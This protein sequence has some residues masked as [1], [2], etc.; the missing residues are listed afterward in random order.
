[1]VKW[2]VLS[3]SFLLLDK[4][5][6][7]LKTCGKPRALPALKLRQAGKVRPFLVVFPPEADP[8]PEGKAGP[9][10]EFPTSFFYVLHPTNYPLNFMANFLRA[11]K[12]ETRFLLII[13]AALLIWAGTAYLSPVAQQER[14]ANAY[15]EDLE[16]QY[17][18]DTYGG[19]TPEET[20]TF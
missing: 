15:L 3:H 14:A 20:K 2:E 18:D 4:S 10:R 5:A 13:S 7:F 17:K 6:R 11:W 19:T 9:S 16:K 1:M 12:F 8:P